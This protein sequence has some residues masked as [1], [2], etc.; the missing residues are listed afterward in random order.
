MR[1]ALVLDMVCSIS[2]SHDRGRGTACSF[3]DVD[4]PNSRRLFTDCAAAVHCRAMTVLRCAKLM[5]IGMAEPCGAVV[6]RAGI[7]ASLVMVF[8]AAR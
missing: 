1:F 4:M 8:M 5:V 7:V 2:S 3:N 6:A